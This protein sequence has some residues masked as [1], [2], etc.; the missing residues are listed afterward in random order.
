MPLQYVRSPKGRDQLLYKGYLHK[1]ERVIGG[2]TLWKCADYHKYHCTG[3][4]HTCSNQVIKYSSHLHP[5]MNKASI[6]AKQV[7][8]DMKEMGPSSQEL[9]HKLA[10]TNGDV[11]P[12]AV[13]SRKPSVQNVK[14]TIQ[15][16]RAC[17]NAARQV[18]SGVQPSSTAAEPVS[19]DPSSLPSFMSLNL[20]EPSDGHID[21]SFIHHNKVQASHSTLIQTSREAGRQ[22]FC[23][24]T[25]LSGE[26]PQEVL[27]RL[28]EAAQQWLCPHEHNKDQIV[29]MVVMEQFLSVLPMDMQM[30]VRTREP[31]GSKEAAQLAETYFRE[32]EPAKTTQDPITFEDVSVHFTEEEWALLGHREKSLYWNVMH[33]NY[34][35][36]A[37]LAEDGTDGKREEDK[38]AWQ[39]TPGPVA[40]L[41]EQSKEDISWSSE[42]DLIRGGCPEKQGESCSGK[43]GE[44]MVICQNELRKLPR[45]GAIMLGLKTQ[46]RCVDCEKWDESPTLNRQKSPDE[47]DPEPMVTSVG[48]HGRLEKKKKQNPEQSLIRGDQN[49]M[50]R[51][52]SKH[53][54]K[55]KEEPIIFR[56]GLKDSGQSSQ[57]SYPNGGDKDE[58]LTH[59]HHLE[60][61]NREG[62]EHMLLSE[63]FSGV[64][65]EGI[66]QSFEQ[67]FQLNPMH[68]YSE[69]SPTEL[70]YSE[71]SPTSALIS[72]NQNIMESQQACSSGKQ[73]GQDK[74][75]G[76]GT[77]GLRVLKEDGLHH[78]AQPGLET[79]PMGTNCGGQ[80]EF[81]KY[82]SRPKSTL[83]E[84]LYSCPKCETQLAQRSDL[85]IQCGCP[86]SE[87]ISGGLSAFIKHRKNDKKRNAFNRTTMQGINLRGKSTKRWNQENR[88]CRQCSFSELRRGLRRPQSPSSLKAL[89]LSVG[90]ETRPLGAGSSSS[91]PQGLKP[92]Q[93]FSCLALLE[94]TGAKPIVAQ[95]M[96]VLQQV[97]VDTAEIKSAVSSLHTTITS[98]YN[99]LGNLS[100]CTDEAEHRISDLEDTSRNTKAQLVQHCSDIKA[101]EAKLIGKAVQTNV[102]AGLWSSQKIKR[103]ARP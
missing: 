8:P 44:N 56:N 63:Q 40:E 3:R 64:S 5:P 68:T 72:K 11:L 21:G 62:S 102:I 16:L 33:Q 57:C 76:S 25:I 7:M 32:L 77:I 86:R 14:Q 103:E 31:G 79:Q 12:G 78:N 75:L 100:G 53:S 87:K 26:A 91:N 94:N 83:G 60:I 9:T 82:I 58:S 29:D 50:E 55:E 19:K 1:K 52:Q 30:W 74:S 42:E 36:V 92:E 51:Q 35:N 49:S 97:A 37:W 43:E 96:A 90:K 71:V 22:R 61:H 15:R 4:A 85:V 81:S 27:T 48:L 17:L 54:G 46:C 98:I 2:K 93:R 70:T 89:Q 24:G 38:D 88:C 66:S 45:D 59:V 99:A 95:L 41:S 23:L 84:D 69:V 73:E 39:G 65:E 34:D 67:D 28:S 13:V 10:A 6:E 101:I 80:D 47:E 20:D 18:A